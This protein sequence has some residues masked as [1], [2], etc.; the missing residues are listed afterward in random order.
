LLDP[1]VAD[2]RPTELE[3]AGFDQRPLFSDNAGCL[4]VVSIGEIS[5]EVGGF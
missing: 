5:P 3:V 2:F 4:L 1:E